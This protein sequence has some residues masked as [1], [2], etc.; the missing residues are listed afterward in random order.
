M[1]LPEMM[2]KLK[3]WPDLSKPRPCCRTMRISGDPDNP[4]FMTTRRP[5]EELDG[6]DVASDTWW[7][8]RRIEE[9]TKFDEQENGEWLAM[10]TGDDYWRMLCIVPGGGN[11]WDSD[12]VT[13]WNDE[14]EAIRYY[15][16]G[17][18]LMELPGPA[19]RQVQ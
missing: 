14:I 18:L 5:T 13:I 9:M 19:D 16:N 8:V 1:K 11:G 15:M 6:D 10:P 3:G 7:D 2:V 17:T 4:E 12:L